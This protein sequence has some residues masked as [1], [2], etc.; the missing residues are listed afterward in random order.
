MAESVPLRMMRPPN[1]TEER[2]TIPDAAATLSPNHSSRIYDSH[3]TRLLKFNPLPQ[4]PQPQV[5]PS[6]AAS[7]STSE[8]AAEQA[9]MTLA[10]Q[11]RCARSKK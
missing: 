4:T 5:S 11:G 2:I 7:E 8:D 6:V 3:N 9:F 1:P 10:T